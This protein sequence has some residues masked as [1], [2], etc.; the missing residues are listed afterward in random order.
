MTNIKLKFLIFILILIFI[1]FIV[2]LFYLQIYS[3][4]YFTKLAFKNNIQF[5]VVP[6]SRGK[7]FSSDKV[8]LATNVSDYKIHFK[9]DFKFTKSIKEIF[10]KELN[11]NFNNANSYYEMRTLVVNKILK[12]SDIE[13]LLKYHNELNEIDIQPVFHRFYP[14]KKIA[15]HILGFTKFDAKFLNNINQF[16]LNE[17]GVAG[18]EKELNNVL[19]GKNGLD[20]YIVDALGRSHKKIE[21]NWSKKP[22]RGNDIVLTINFKLQKFIQ[23]NY[24]PDKNGA[25]IVMNPNNGD[26]L[27]LCSFPD[28]DVNKF[29]LND[30]ERIEILK[31]DRKILLNRC[32]QGGY[33][34]GSIFKIFIALK[35][36][37]I[38][39]D[40]NRTFYCSGQMHLGNRV[41]R[42]WKDTGHNSMNLRTAIINSCNIFFY[43][44]GMVMGYDNI[45][46]MLT[47]FEF[48][49]Y[50]NITLPY[51]IKSVIPTREYLKRNKLTFTQGDL[52]NLSIGQGMITLTP[53]KIA[54]AVSAIANNGYLYRP[55][56]IKE[57]IRP[58]NQIIEWER[59]L[60][61]KL[62]FTDKDMEY[63]KECMVDVIERGTG[64]SAIHKNFKRIVNFKVA[65]KT[66]TAQ[67]IANPLKLKN[68]VVKPHS[69]F[70]CFFPVEHPRYVILTLFENSGSG[71]EVAVPF[72]QNI[73]EYIAQ[74]I[75]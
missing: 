60:I 29:V 71:S 31:S 19:V 30:A 12:I 69:W 20:C 50:T 37:S 28:Y 56:L 66:G 45:L 23:D 2:N 64:Y 33:P 13:K 48:N 39:G 21:T 7:I 41:L 26:I 47:E 54:T 49:K 11:I 53:I 52:V 5:K 9:P 10:S 4:D 51:E 61:K 75:Y 72:T 40:L 1:I 62:K 3:I 17:N 6:Y 16:E 43:N 22:E 67:V 68:L 34:P 74:N 70:I 32:I 27:A 15:S 38:G 42:C 73:I 57:I 65:G 8:I 25:V 58:D 36:I 46:N 18:I 44:L 55:N 59:Q 35:Y 63:L 24:P 14:Q